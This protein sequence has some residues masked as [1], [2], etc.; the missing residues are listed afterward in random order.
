MVAGTK[1]EW[2]GLFVFCVQHPIQQ[3][4]LFIQLSGRCAQT[5]KELWELKVAST[6]IPDPRIVFTLGM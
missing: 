3:E 6:G 4:G 1:T 5:H 2:K